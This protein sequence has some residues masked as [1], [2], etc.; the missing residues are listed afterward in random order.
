MNTKNFVS[1]LLAL[2]IG[3]CTAAWAQQKGPAASK[4]LYAKDPLADKQAPPSAYADK[5]LPELKGVLSWK[6][7]GEVKP[8]KQKDKFVPEFAK[9]VSALDKKEV[10]IQGFMMPLDMGE[11]Q[12]RFILSAL[13]PSCSFCLPGGPE[14]MIEVQAK[15]PV[16]YGFEPILLTGK[17][18]VLKDDPMGLYYRLTD[19]V[20]T[21]AK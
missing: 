9:A 19:A 8:V 1:A 17:L 14:Q 3:V 11:K 18:A 12:T 10:K 4:D 6:T 5:P 13:P 20:V 2:L 21:V 7:L 15:S 16:K